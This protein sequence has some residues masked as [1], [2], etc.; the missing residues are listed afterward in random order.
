[1]GPRGARSSLKK[2]TLFTIFNY[3]N[4]FKIVFFYASAQQPKVRKVKKK[5]FLRDLV[6]TSNTLI[7]FF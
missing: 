1:V 7:D 4:I 3:L 2:K 6:N 5:S